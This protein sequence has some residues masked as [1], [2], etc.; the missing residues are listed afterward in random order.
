MTS[1]SR[2][3][4]SLVVD[5]TR[6]E[7][8]DAELAQA[9]FTREKWAVTETWHRFAPMV[10]VTARRTLGSQ[11]DADDLVQDVFLQVF[12][13]VNGLRDPASLRS[14]VYSIALRVLRSHLR[15][16]RVRSWLSFQSPETLLDVRHSTPDVESRDLLRNFYALLDRLSARDRL[17]FL[18][19]RAES[20]TVEEIAD[21]MGIST[22]TVKRSLSHA[23]GR[24]SRW[25][26]NDPGMSALVDA[27]GGSFG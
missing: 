26:D 21:L 22:S 18:L 17:V 11:S 3:S 24:L 8:S 19:R 12:R 10:L 7:V 27:L 20:M 6:G 4:L 23:T 9:L 1:P 14:F 13:N 15:R 5:R 2:V 25:I 16:R